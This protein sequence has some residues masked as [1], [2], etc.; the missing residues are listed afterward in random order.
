MKIIAPLALA[1]DGRI[2]WSH[3][4]M[5]GIP[6][7]EDKIRNTAWCFVG[8]LSSPVKVEKMGSTTTIL[9]FN[10]SFVLYLV[11]SI[12]F[13]VQVIFSSVCVGGLKLCFLRYLKGGRNKC[14][15]FHEIVL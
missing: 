14:A 10:Y 4:R 12:C 5:T 2:M 8:S 3:N 7:S 6:S 13:L 1:E 11:P 15:I 9:F